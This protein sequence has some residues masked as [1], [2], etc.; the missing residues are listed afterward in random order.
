M[1]TRTKPPKDP[2]VQS[3]QVRMWFQ[4]VL[5][6]AAEGSKA[7]FRCLL[8]PDASDR[9]GNEE[10]LR[11]W[12][13]GRHRPQRH[14]L[15]LLEAVLPGSHWF[16]E[17]WLWDAIARNYCYEP[18]IFSR[19]RETL[20]R[21]H[22]EQILL[23]EEPTLPIG[24]IAKAVGA[25]A[26]NWTSCVLYMELLGAHLVRFDSC[27]LAGEAMGA[28]SA[29]RAARHSLGGLLSHPTIRP[30]ATD[31]YSLFDERFALDLVIAKHCHRAADRTGYRHEM[32][33]L[34]W[35]QAPD[36]PSCAQVDW[37]HEAQG[38]RFSDAHPLL[39]RR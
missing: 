11:G 20:P 6:Y 23:G 21:A 13:S 10:L 39:F 22:A 37:E 17:F 24:D 4:L 8:D 3:I 18:G 29:L 5:L 14:N 7:T 19:Y 26:S 9:N 36:T 34:G 30:L 28:L 38:T 16:M 15:Y 12:E 32:M 33:E 1:K 31:F 35:R 2:E 27:V 25:Q